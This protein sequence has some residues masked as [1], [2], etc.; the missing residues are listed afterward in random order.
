MMLTGTPT[1]IHAN[2]M[3]AETHKHNKDT[4]N[5]HTHMHTLTHT[6]PSVL[7]PSICGSCAF[8]KPIANAAKMHVCVCVSNCCTT[9]V[10]EGPSTSEGVQTRCTVF[11]ACVHAKRMESQADQHVSK[12]Q[13]SSCWSP[14]PWTPAHCGRHRSWLPHSDGTLCE[15]RTHATKTMSRVHAFERC[16][17]NTHAAWFGDDFPSKPNVDQKDTW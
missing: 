4:K 3:H 16:H 2:H 14:F 1:Q 7:D 6:H 10:V 15:P 8:Q 17:S 11:H 5:T 13:V 12:L 9:W